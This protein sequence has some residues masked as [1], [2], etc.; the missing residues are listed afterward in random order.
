M[1]RFRGSYR[2]PDRP[3][4]ERRHECLHERRKGLKALRAGRL[5][6]LD[7]IFVSAIVRD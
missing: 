1:A 3:P 4:Y 6:A 5:R 2:M 7:T